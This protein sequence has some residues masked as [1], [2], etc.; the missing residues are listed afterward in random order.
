HLEGGV[1][2]PYI[3]SWPGRF[4]K[5]AV[6]RQVVS[7]L[8]IAPTAAALAGA[9]L[10]RGTDGENLAPYLSSAKPKTFERRLFWRSGPNFAIRDGAWKLWSVNRAEPGETESTA[11]GITPDG[12]QAKA[13]SQGVYDMLYNLADDPGESR[14]LAA[15]RPEVV[16][17]LKAEIAEWDRGNVPAQWT[18][19]RQAVRR[20]EGQMLKIYP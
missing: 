3:V 17:R 14:N 20:H 4:R 13:S 12:V 1:R 9:A 6:D 5:G 7:S 15:T 19:M 18:S 2:V 8:D 16:A 11:A 10:P